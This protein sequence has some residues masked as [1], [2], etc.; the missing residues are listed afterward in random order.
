MASCLFLNDITPNILNFK[1]D[2]SFFVLSKNDMTLFGF[3]SK[4]CGMRVI[5][6]NDKHIQYVSVY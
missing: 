3:T 6:M 4:R 5:Y 2:L 1:D